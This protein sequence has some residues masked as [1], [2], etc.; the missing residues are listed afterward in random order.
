MIERITTN[1][2]G[3][4]YLDIRFGEGHSVHE[5]LLDATLLAA[6][7][8]ADGFLPPGLPVLATGGPVSGAGQ[9]AYGIIGPEAVKLGT[10]NT[11]GNMIFSGGLNRDAIEA[12]LGRVLSAN[13]LSAIA[14]AA[15]LPG[16]VLK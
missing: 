14:A 9:A 7:R 3:V 2:G 15:G 8:N 1:T 13:E 5:G 16:V 11:F 4:S 12:N 6:S 10:I